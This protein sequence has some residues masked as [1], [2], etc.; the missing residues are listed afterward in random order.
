MHPPLGVAEVNVRI[1][2][3]AVVVIV[4]SWLMGRLISRIGQPPVIGEIIAGI[5]LGPSL[6]GDLLPDVAAYLFPQPVINALSML[7]QIGLVMFMFLIGLEMDFASLRGQGRRMALTAG[8][9]ITVPFAL[10]AGV[11]V[12]LY[13]AYGAGA[14]EVVFCLFFGAAMAITAFPV[15]ARILRE[16]GL[17]KTKIGA[18]SLMCAAV[19]DV[20]AWCLVAVVVAISSVSGP[21]DALRTAGL[22]VIYVIVMVTVVRPLL[23]RVPEIP[24]WLVLAVAL[25][26]AW[27]AEQAGVHVIFGGFMAGAVMPRRPDWQRSVQDRLEAVVSHLLLPIFFVITGLS[28]HLDQLATT[29]LWVLA[30]VIVVATVGKLSGSTPFARLTGQSWTDALTLGVLMNARGLTEIV[31]LSVGLQLEIITPTLFTIMVL[32]ALGTTL[33]APPLLRVLIRPATTPTNA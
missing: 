4:F 20:V 22:A 24:I 23:A 14:N 29:D 5:L 21:V 30:A 11:A 17:I 18:L 16:F 33:L 6:L 9:S 2:L 8:T 31:V 27:A 19:N 3:A 1:L 28:T 7:A 13:P 10:A 25:L 26:S 32:M 15:L 12:A